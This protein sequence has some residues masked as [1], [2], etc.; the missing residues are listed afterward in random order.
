M[1]GKSLGGF[2]EK[3][4]EKESLFIDR[5][6]LQSS[7][8]PN[9]ISHRYEQIDQ[10]ASI[11]APTL[12]KELPSNLFIYGKTGTGKTLTIQYISDQLMKVAKEKNLPLNILYLN[13]KLK[14]LEVLKNL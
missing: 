9:E 10:I 8:I 5:G 1:R 7:Y 11:L 13:C 4:V 12:K 6:A 3:Y 2:F 14:K